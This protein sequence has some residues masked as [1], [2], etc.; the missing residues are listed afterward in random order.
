M[1]NRACVPVL[2]VAAVFLGACERPRQD[3][4]D[5]PQPSRTA[6]TAALPDTSAPAV[7]PSSAARDAITDSIISTRIKAGILS[8][9]G[10][11]GSD[12]SVNTDRGVV[13][14]TGMVK[15][16]E[17]AAIASAHAQ[18]QDGVMRVDNQLAA[19]LH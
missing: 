16:Q 1:K 17:Q 13:A 14:L 12:V 5:T 18:R 3:T 9:P 15:S 2:V 19:N 8:D 10:M 4:A 7:S 6:P 11:V